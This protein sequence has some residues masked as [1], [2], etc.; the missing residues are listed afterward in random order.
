[1]DDHAVAGFY[2][3]YG[4][5]SILS[6]NTAQCTFLFYQLVWFL[7]SIDYFSYSF[8]IWVEILE[9]DK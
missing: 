9:I 4:F 8:V 7:G 3:N 1:M 5:L 2:L 6:L